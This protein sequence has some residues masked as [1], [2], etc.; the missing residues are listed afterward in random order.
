MNQEQ[1]KDN[2]NSSSDQEIEAGKNTAIIAYLTIVG[3]I[4]AF[5]MNNEKKNPFS[6]YHIRQVLGLAVTGL[7][8]G[9]V[10]II[11]I[12]GWLVAIVGAVVLLIMWVSG[13]INAVNGREKPMP[14]FG[15]QYTKWFKGA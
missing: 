3:L 8:I 10:G 11:P 9:V 2:I 15:K 14:I 1:V 7:V 6:A 4:V 5:I 13:L 12:L